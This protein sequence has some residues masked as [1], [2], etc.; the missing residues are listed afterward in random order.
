[1]IACCGI[2]VFT[3]Y[4]LSGI[5]DTGVA[6][7]DMHL[8]YSVSLILIGMLFMIS[9]KKAIGQ[10]IG[11][12]V[13]ENGLF[14]TALFATDGMPFLVDLGTSVDLITAVMIMGIMI[15]RINEKFE[16]INVEK[17]NKLKG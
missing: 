3:Y 9:R 8:V 6:G 14:V 7:A 4:I 17:L 1:M 12:L 10:M 13:I 5:G 15:F 11:F 16:T 2:V